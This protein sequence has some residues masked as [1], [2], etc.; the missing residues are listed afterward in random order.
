MKFLKRLL[1][2]LLKKLLGISYI[3][4]LERIDFLKK[5]FSGS[6][7]SLNNI[8]KKIEK[9]LN[10]KNGF[11]VELGANDG[12]RQSNTLYFELKKNWKGVL[13]EPSPNNFQKCLT[14]R[15]KRNS[16]FCN[17]CVGFEYKDKYVDMK[18]ANLMTFS[19]NLN[20]D[21]NKKVFIKDSKKYLTQDE[22][23]ISFGAKARTLNSILIEANAPKIIDFLSI[24]VEGAEIEVLKGIDFDNFYF[25]YIVIE[26]I[27]KKKISHFLNK[28]NYIFLEK[29]T[30]HDYLF[31]NSKI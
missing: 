23:I 28:Y 12:V 16:I 22:V 8:D 29:L 13:I 4:V 20:L 9:Y 27:D 21:I 17:A 31:K 24:D 18:Y 25:R 6:Y 5:K 14:N 11:F 2:V 10:Y 30:Y 1:K 19:D 26:A 15:S 3:P 7:F